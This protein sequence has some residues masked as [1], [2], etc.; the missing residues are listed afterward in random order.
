MGILLLALV[1]RSLVYFSA[2][3]PKR[4]L[5]DDA[6]LYVAIA[7]DLRGAYLDPLSP[8]FPIGLFR[9]PGYPL[10]LAA[11]SAVFKDALAPVVVAQIGLSLLT[12][13]LTVLLAGRLLGNRAAM[14]AGL[15]LAVDPVSALFS[16]FIQPEALFTVLLVGGVLGVAV[17]AE[18]GDP[19]A[20]LAAGL[21]LGLAALSRPIGLF[22]PLAVAP[23]ILLR[24]GKARRGFVALAFLLGS[25]VP[26][27]GW[28]TK[29]Q[30]VTGAPVF[31]IVGDSSLLHYRAAGA[32]AE[33]EGISIEEAR[34][35][36]WKRFSSTVTPGASVVDQ[37]RLQ[38]AVALE[39]LGEH[40]LAAIRMMV[41]GTGRL[42]A[43]TGLTAL[44]H[45]RGES[46]P[47]AVS[48][49]WKIVA[50]GLQGL[51]LLIAYL[52]VARAVM[53]MSWRR[54]FFEL[55]LSLGVVVYFVVLSAG[56]EANTRFRFPVA[57]FLA[58]LAGHGLSWRR[59]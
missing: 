45:L 27:G 14:A 24:R 49:P 22:L 53:V 30:I 56:P 26:I 59:T 46:S 35:R 47:G 3:D 4:F 9:T 37:S 50:Q 36:V 23:A 55:A 31:T 2:A 6:P 38:R 25:A 5:T 29:N 28:M 16:C 43:G 17:A 51:A 19:L 39:V 48:R 7:K 15:V 8:M 18:R 52:A 42:L 11:L 44:S 32:L 58:V 20:A 21:L 33:D 1:V 34:E 40:K 12:V 57:P 10:F 41:Y 54:Q 13:W